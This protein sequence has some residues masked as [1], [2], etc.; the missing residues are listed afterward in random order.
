MK[1][2]IIEDTGYF[3]NFLKE[4]FNSINYTTEV[5]FDGD[6]IADN[7]LIVR[8]FDVIL[9]DMNLPAIRFYNKVDNIP[10][11]YSGI[12]ILRRI[13]EVSDIPVII[14]SEINYSSLKE[15]VKDFKNV[16]C[17]TKN[18]LSFDPDDLR[19]LVEAVTSKK[20]K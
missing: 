7:S 9:L 10:S 4:A 13:R 20:S 11:M 16:T 19:K 3:I 8:E 2:L 5:S 6:I 15:Y 17:I 18:N 1:V 14:I 12:L